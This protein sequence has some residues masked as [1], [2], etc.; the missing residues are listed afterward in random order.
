MVA[1]HIHP[2]RSSEASLPDGHYA[3]AGE[4]HQLGGFQSED[5]VS[6]SGGGPDLPLQQEGL[7]HERLEPLG[8]SH[9]RHPADGEAG[10]L[11]HVGGIGHLDRLGMEVGDPV[12]V[13]AALAGEDEHGPPRISAPQD[14]RLDDLRDPDTESLRRLGRAARGPLELY[15]LRLESPLLQGTCTLSTPLC[16]S[17]PI[18]SSRC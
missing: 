15:D 5:H 7:V 2:T 11:A 4:S 13:D 12:H 1:T 9:G 6:V 16:D 10:L 18:F 3:P 17:S 14:L 8:V